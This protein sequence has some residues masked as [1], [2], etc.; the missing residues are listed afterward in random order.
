MSTEIKYSEAIEELESIVK[1]IENEEITIDKMSAKVKRAAELI[2]L[3]KKALTVTED[4]V[5]GILNELE[6]H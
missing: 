6:S 2:A 1:E 3:C 4:E 5:K